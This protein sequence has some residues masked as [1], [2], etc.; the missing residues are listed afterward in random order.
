MNGNYKNQ[1]KRR[2]IKNGFWAIVKSIANLNRNT[3]SHFID[4]KIKMN[5]IIRLIYDDVN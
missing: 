5:L 3:L 1:N 4:I 2:L